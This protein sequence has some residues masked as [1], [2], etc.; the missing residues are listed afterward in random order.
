M[1]ERGAR[2]KFAMRGVLSAVVCCE[3]SPRPRG[4]WKDPRTPP[5]ILYLVFSV[6]SVS[7]FAETALLT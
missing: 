5:I 7:D 1:S 4:A 2:H 6:V 3:G